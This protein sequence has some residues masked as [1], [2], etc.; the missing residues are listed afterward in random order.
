MPDLLYIIFDLYIVFFTLFDLYIVFFFLSPNL[1]AL[2]M[3][4]RTDMYSPVGIS[5]SNPL[6]KELGPVLHF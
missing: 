3:G 6:A 1:Y 2:Y 4:F 5:E